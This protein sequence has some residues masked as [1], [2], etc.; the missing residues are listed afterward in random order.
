VGTKGW[1]AVGY[2]YLLHWDGSI[3]WL[4]DITAMSYH[5]HEHNHDAVG[6]CLAGD[7]SHQSP[8]LVMLESLRWL[9]VKLK[10]QVPWAEVR[11]HRDLALPGWETE[12]PGGMW[13]LFRG[14][15]SEN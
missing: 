5:I 11:G 1:P 3:D 15:T 4:H 6:I 9:I 13:D 12:C 14:I 10:A 2:H 7:W 8:P